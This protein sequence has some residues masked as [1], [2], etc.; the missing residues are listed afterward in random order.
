MLKGPTPY[1]RIKS[2]TSSHGRISVQRQYFS[3]AMTYYFPQLTSRKPIIS[4]KC[5]YLP[6]WGVKWGCF[7]S[8]TEAITN[9]RKSSE[10]VW[11]FS[12]SQIKNSQN[13]RMKRFDCWAWEENFKS[14]L[15]LS[16]RV[17]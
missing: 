15:H 13:N 7:A 12:F 8:L 10:I 11:P 1:Y 14:F 3:E 9:R 2:K 4:S 16:S 17:G 6:F 5:L